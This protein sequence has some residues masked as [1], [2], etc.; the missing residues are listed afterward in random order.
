MTAT[1]LLPVEL[2]SLPKPPGL[3]IL[4]NLLQID[5]AR[6][7]L[8]L[9]NWATQHGGFYQLKMAHQTALVVS[10]WQVITDVLRAR[11]KTFR[12]SSAL[13]AV[14]ADLG[15]SG[16]LSAEGE[17]WQRHRRLTMRAF[18][19]GHLRDYFP[20]LVKI[21]ERLRQH[22]LRAAEQGTAVDVQADLLRYSVDVTAGLAFG[23]EIDTIN[24]N[25]Q[26]LH[27]CLS[28]VFPAINRRLN[29][30]I[31]YWRYIK[32]PS[33]RAL[34]RNMAG[35]RL[36]VDSFIEDARER[37]RNKPELFTKPGN[38]IEAFLAVRDQP[39][40]EFSDEDIYGNIFTTLLVGPDS[41]AN[42]FSWITYFL[43]G[44]GTAQAAVRAEADAL[45]G[46]DPV[47][48]S[49]E[50]ITTM[51]YMEAVTHEAM[52]LK[53][54]GPILFLEA[55]HEAQVGNV[56]VM[57][58]TPII[59]LTR[60]GGMEAQH[61]A[62]PE[63]FNPARWLD[64]AASAANPHEIGC[65]DAVSPK[66]VVMP[67]GAGARLCSGRY[68]ALVQI[69]MLGAMLARNFNV[70]RIG[71]GQ[72]NERFKFSMEPVDLKIKLTQRQA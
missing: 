23:T 5:P 48:S 2:H 44:D 22:W 29:S 10:D 20:S 71:Q 37:M 66:R 57:P 72:I 1:V 12:R 69:K 30:P 15:M 9:E 50:S 63:R 7:H 24:G 21:T 41:T 6:I 61:F 31:P 18:D 47:P 55:N 51:P 32:L 25:N 8:T 16:L 28:D 19:P 64:T 38:L 54:S 36:Q 11:P 34:D 45:F 43:C 27:R 59:A 67:F 4:G 46:A 40:S 35:L 14:F 3:P 52:R 33:D 58:G 26:S 13:G 42:V 62:A 17:Q 39:G 56:R 65:P 49:F 70:E 60:M 68:L 53:P